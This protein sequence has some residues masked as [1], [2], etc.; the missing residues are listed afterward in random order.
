MSDH[1]RT[2]LKTHIAYTNDAYSIKHD[3]DFKDG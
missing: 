2:K 3:N 1:S